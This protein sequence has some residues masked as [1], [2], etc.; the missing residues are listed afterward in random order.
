MTINAPCTT[1]KRS[2]EEEIDTEIKKIKIDQPQQPANN[3]VADPIT[4]SSP[5]F[6]NA[7]TLIT[8]LQDIS[9]DEL[10]QFTLDFE[11]KHGI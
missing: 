9:D 3:T 2:F 8:P 5:G 10:L 6:V 4:N 7:S 1:M 11:R